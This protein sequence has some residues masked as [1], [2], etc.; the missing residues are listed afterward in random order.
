M[1][2]TIDLCESAKY[3]RCQL[4]TLRSYVQRGL[5]TP[6]EGV[7][8]GID[9]YYSFDKKTLDSFVAKYAVAPYNGQAILD[10]DDFRIVF[11]IDEEVV[12]DYAEMCNLTPD[13][14]LPPSPY[15]TGMR[16]YRTTAEQFV[17]N[18]NNLRRSS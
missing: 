5:I 4:N 12:N 15:E 6:V 14:R 10:L 16:Y 9:E 17:E 11:G 8:T 7:K 13:V 1:T 18:F 3:L 2:K